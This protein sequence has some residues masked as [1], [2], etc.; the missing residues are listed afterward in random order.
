MKDA[1]KPDHASL[2]TILT[3]LKDGRYVIPNFQRDFEWKPWDISALM[4]SIFLDY[5]VG[6]LLLWKGKKENFDA[7]CCEAVYGYSGQENK[8]YIVLDGQ[9]RLTAIYYA[10][11]APDVPLPSRTNRAVYFIKVDEFM[12]ENYDAAFTYDWLSKRFSKTLKSPELQYAN[13]IFPLS[14]IGAGGWELPNWVQGY[15][16]HWEK[17]RASAEAAGDTANI[18]QATRYHENAKAFG[19]HL[20]GITQQY[21]I[22]YIELDRELQL[23]KVCDIF[24]QINSRGV[25]LDVFDLINALLTPKGIQ[26]KQMW[27]DAKPRLEF[28]DS[29]KMN[30]YI[31]QVMSILRQGY[32][33]PNYLYFLLPNQPK[34]VRDP[35]GTRRVEILI[36]ATA[37]FKSAWDEAVEALEKAIKMLRHPQEFG[38]FSSNYLPYVTILPAFSALQQY[39]S[40][41]PHLEHLSGQRK[42]RHWYWASIF[43]NRYSGSVESTSARDFFDVKAWID[44]D[45]LEPEL[46]YEFKDRYRSLDLRKEIK[47]GTSIY[48]GI[49]NLLVLRG[50]RDWITGNIPEY[51]D[52][53]DHHIVPVDWGNKNLKD[54]KVHT[55]LNRAPLSSKTNRNII[56][57]K[58]PNEYLPEWI[59]KNGKE[60]VSSIL[61]SHFI[62]PLALDILLRDPFCPEDFE[63]FISERQRTLL[64]AIESLLIKDRLDL[65]P[66]LQA[67]DKR[68]EAIELKLRK[69]LVDNSPINGLVVPQ[70]IEENVELRV[71]KALKRNASFNAESF[72]SLEGRLQFFDLREI[73]GVIASK[74]NW[75]LF[76]PVFKSKE[77][78]ITK[79]D[80]MAE[81]RNG[82]RHSRTV[83]KT[84]EMEGEASIIW[85][86]SLLAN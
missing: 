67:L 27:R 83:T 35:D 13:H 58:L 19:D 41:K 55:I 36:P 11:V 39:L 10:F 34:S 84:T 49:F 66:N 78:L 2:D 30:V 37:D 20:R 40:K 71:K 24:T 17:R 72:E 25:R 62:S 81:L 33:S 23:D 56:S 77:A 43:N 7:L 51:D 21:Q 38:V 54:S 79:F 22:S 57:N 32:C 12:N 61:E 75:I 5:Y 70:L 48:N 44:D 8:E 69:L 16:N 15:Q 47:R 80:Q 73:E 52:L 86:E 63:E 53:D 76:E 31:L 65:P 3:R 59:N 60:Q 74:A 42:I 14:I 45:A 9:Q 28:V 18:E 1:Q 50:A 26:L 85:F 6:S 64:D 68:I 82:I 4:R 46:I 29:E